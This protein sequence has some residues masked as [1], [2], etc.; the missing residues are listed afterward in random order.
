MA[1]GTMH[2]SYLC[3]DVSST[4]I[5]ISS[6][7]FYTESKKIWDIKL[8]YFKPPHEKG[9][10]YNLN[11]TFDSISEIVSSKANHLKGELNVVIEEAPLFM[12]GGGSSAG[13]IRIL[14]VYTRIVGLAVLRQTQ[15]EPVYYPVATIRASLRKLVGIDEK[16]QKEEVPA[17][18]EK[19]V[20]R[21]N[22]E[23]WMFPYIKKE[24]K[25][26]RK[27]KKLYEDETYDM[28]DSLAVGI[29]ALYKSGFIK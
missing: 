29:T 20:G 18:L 11:E 19:I 21:L 8:D 26:K 24:V 23:P 5:G 12:T 13:T 15:L 14:G 6:F 2:K 17:A 25:G 10:I 28:A 16:I 3:F 27:S 22:L 7:D 4:T 1:E 9:E